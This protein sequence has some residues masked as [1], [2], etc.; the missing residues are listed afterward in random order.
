MTD[1][2]PI[3]DQFV[4]ELKRGGW[5]RSPQYPYTWHSKTQ[6]TVRLYP[7]RS[8]LALQA[9]S[10]QYA[11]I[12]LDAGAFAYVSAFEAAHGIAP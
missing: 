11:D 4:A 12:P 10:G 2:I 8:H 3:Y 7:F 9:P 1:A 6:V 5:S